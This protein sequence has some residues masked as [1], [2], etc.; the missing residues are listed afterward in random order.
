MS[1][2][3]RDRNGAGSEDAVPQIDTASIETAIQR[4]HDEEPPARPLGPIAMWVRRVSLIGVFPA[5][6]V[7]YLTQ[8]LT[9]ELPNRELPVSPR[10][11]PTTI[12]VVMVLVTTAIAAMEIVRIVRKRQ[13]ESDGLNFGEPEDDDRERITHWPDAWIALGALVV[14]ILVFAFLGFEISTFAFLFGLS[15]YYQPR[16]WLRNLIASVVF[17]VLVYV[18]FAHL[19]GV[20]LPSG[21]L[22]GI[23]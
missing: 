11:F 18:L 14:Y 7:F 17:A 15:T 21:L 6:A 8:A 22:K 1:A 16:K 9:L 23:L 12:A 4:E 5:F 20:Q 2:K 10:S 19:L 3:G 13:A